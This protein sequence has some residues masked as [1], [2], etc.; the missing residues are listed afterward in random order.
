MLSKNLAASKIVLV[1][2]L[3]MHACTQCSRVLRAGLFPYAQGQSL[4]IVW[5]ERMTCC[6]TVQAEGVRWLWQES[7]FADSG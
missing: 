6:R 3:V 1:H 4:D 7:I 2:R 5:T